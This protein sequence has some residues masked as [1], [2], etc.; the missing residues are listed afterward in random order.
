MRPA[1]E[2]RA[3]ACPGRRVSATAVA[4]QPVSRPRPRPQAPRLGLAGVRRCEKRVLVA[5][6][7]AWDGP[8]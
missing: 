1:V 5:E 8:R 4:G 6:G 3:A 2:E 7:P